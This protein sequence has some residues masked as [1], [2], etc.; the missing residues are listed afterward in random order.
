MRE[1]VT[2]WLK[3]FTFQLIIMVITIALI[4]AFPQWSGLV[5]AIGMIAIGQ[6]AAKLKRWLWP[7]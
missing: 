2:K 4:E 3:D 6:M 5:A 1:K 7:W